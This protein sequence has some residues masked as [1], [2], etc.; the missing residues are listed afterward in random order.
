MTNI[1]AFIAIDLPGNILKEIKNIQKKLPM[2]T[3]KK[4]EPENLHLTLKFLGNVDEKVLSNV[5]KRLREIKLKSFETQINKI[6]FFDNQKSRNY[7]R[8]IIVWLHMTDCNELQKNVDNVLNRL[9]EKERRF[10]SHLTIARIKYVKNKTKFFKELGKIK[11]PQ[12]LN[13]PVKN[14]KLK[15]SALSRKGPVYEDLETYLLEQ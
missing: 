15:E 14:F 4:T 5:K 8:Q 11:I 12:T 9:F 7:N 6:G 3:G 2:F 10:M 13:F 1:R